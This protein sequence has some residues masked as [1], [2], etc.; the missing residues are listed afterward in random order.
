[1]VWYL[2]LSETPDSHFEI[3][4]LDTFSSAP[5]SSCDIPFVFLKSISFSLKFIVILLWLVFKYKTSIADRCFFINQPLLAICQ[6]HITTAKFNYTCHKERN[7]DRLVIFFLLTFIRLLRFPDWVAHDRFQSAHITFS[8][9]AQIDFVMVSRV[10]NIQ[11][12]S[13]RFH[14]V[15]H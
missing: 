13:I 12:V 2:Y 11:F 14:I 5:N 1:M 7:I 3:V 4:C 8:R 6:P 15:V 9:I 10:R